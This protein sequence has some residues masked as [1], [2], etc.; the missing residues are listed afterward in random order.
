MRRRFCPNC[1]TALFSH[2]SSRA[3]VM[4]VRVGTLDDREVGGPTS[5]IW[6]SSAPSWGFVDADLP[7]CTGQPAP[8]ALK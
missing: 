7:N 3:E 8:V 1:G 2:S 4:V 5:F 6:T